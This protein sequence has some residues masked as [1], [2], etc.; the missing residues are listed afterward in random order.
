MAKHIVSIKYSRSNKTVSDNPNF[1]I[2][3]LKCI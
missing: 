3:R 1:S 2:Q